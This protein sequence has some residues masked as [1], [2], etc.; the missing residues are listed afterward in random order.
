MLHVAAGLVPYREALAWQDDLHARR[1]TEEIDDV[2]L[3]LEHEAVYTAGRY[4]D[5]ARNLTGRR[6]DIP[7]VR[8][9]RGGD[10]TYHGPGQLVAYPILRLEDPRDVRGYVGAL[11][12]AC[13]EVVASYGIAA[14]SR[15]EYPGLWV[16]DE[17]IAAIGVRVHRGVT[18]HGL[19]LNV[20]T[21]LDDFVGIVPCGIR[22]GGVCSLQSLGVEAQL[23]EVEARLVAALG[24]AL[25]R[26][27][28]ATS[29]A[30]ADALLRRRRHVR[31]T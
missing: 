27:V 24:A 22:E 17:K 1:I 4:A 26:P 21:D 13:R 28:Y 18:K 9:D 20:A 12:G 30:E 2:L 10:V 15:S 14:R 3:T 31:A 11:E 6:P 5:L 8:I 16:G 29:A 19:A 25:G 23:Q 7:V